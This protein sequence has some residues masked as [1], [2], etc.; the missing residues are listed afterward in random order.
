MQGK[1]SHRTIEP[2][3]VYSTRGNWLLIAF[4]R[5]RHDFR[6][7]RLDCIE[8]LEVLNQHFDSHNMTL[9]EYFE[10]CQKKYFRYP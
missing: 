8:E 7:F 9:Q 1:V 5:L 3:A 4:C 10:I 6:S 2:F